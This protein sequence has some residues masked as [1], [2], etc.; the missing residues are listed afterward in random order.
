[1][2][3]EYTDQLYHSMFFSIFLAL[4]HCSM[5]LRESSTLLDSC[6]VSCNSSEYQCTVCLLAAADELAE[7][8]SFVRDGAIKRSQFWVDSLLD[9]KRV[10]ISS[11]K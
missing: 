2:P 7:M 3:K 1:M 6:K 10:R 5:C 4:L 8:L 9:C 11:R